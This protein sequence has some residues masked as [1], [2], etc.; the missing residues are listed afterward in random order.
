M[1]STEK[2]CVKIMLPII[3]FDYMASIQHT[4]IIY[5]SIIIDTTADA[6]NV[7]QMFC[8]RKFIE[9]KQNPIDVKE[10]FIM[11]FLWN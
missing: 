2:I 6:V 5:F 8:I 9:I 7:E 10:P 11:S 3:I 1:K 4:H